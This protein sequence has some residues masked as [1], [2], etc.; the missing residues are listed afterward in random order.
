MA[1]LQAG[2]SGGVVEPRTRM[3]R[4]ASSSAVKPCTAWAP[5]ILKGKN[6]YECHVFWKTTRNVL[7]LY[8]VKGRDKKKRSFGLVKSVKSVNK[9][10]V[11]GELSDYF[12]VKNECGDEVFFKSVLFN[13]G[14]IGSN[15]FSKMMIGLKTS[16]SKL[17]KYISWLVRSKEFYQHD[18]NIN[19]DLGLDIKDKQ[20]DDERTEFENFIACG[21]ENAT[22][23]TTSLRDAVDMI[24]DQ[25][26]RK[27]KSEAKDQPYKRLK[28]NERIDKYFKVEIS[29]PDGVEYQVATAGKGRV[30]IPVEQLS[31]CEK[32]HIPIDEGK[33]RQLAL[34]MIERFEPTSIYL[35]VV[36]A[37]QEDFDPVNLER[38]R[39]EVVHGRHRFSALKLLHK[40][41]KM[42]SLPTMEGGTVTCYVLG[43]SDDIG[44]NYLTLRGNDLAAKHVNKPSLHD[45]FYTLQGLSLIYSDQE[46]V[47]KAITRFANLQ[48][49]SDAQK[50]ALRSF[51]KWTKDA[52]SKVKDVL[53]KYER[54]QVKDADDA[55]MKKHARDI[56]EGKK[57]ICSSELFTGLA[58]M[59]V[60][61]FEENAGDIMSG[62][63]SLK[64]VVKSNALSNNLKLVRKK[65][66]A[67]IVELAG[68]TS[69]ENVRNLY[70][71]K[72][73]EDVIDKLPVQPQP[74]SSASSL[75]KYTV[76][77]F[78]ND[79]D[80]QSTAKELQVIELEQD[81]EELR[82]LCVRAKRK[83]VKEMIK[84]NI[85]TVEAK[86]AKINPASEVSDPYEF[87]VDKSLDVSKSLKLDKEEGKSQEEQQKPQEEQQKSQEEQRKSQQEQ[88]KSQQEQQKSQQEQQK[89]EE[90]ATGERKQPVHHG[91]QVDT[92]KVDLER[93]KDFIRILHKGSHE[94]DRAHSMNI[95]LIKSF[96]AKQEEKNPFSNKEIDDFIDCMAK[97]KK[98]MRSSDIVFM[99]PL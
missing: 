69:I 19:T 97:E 62:K 38:N 53:V 24:A 48:K 64:E 36:P 84:Q 90:T 52:L 35:T 88:Q 99:I 32:V 56:Q 74:S 57:F 78:K 80:A 95:Q 21:K 25:T 54:F 58:R 79:S 81:L 93:Y 92:M 37:V 49:C 1:D 10:N 39:Y 83:N 3:Q 34:G 16:G 72:F 70:P 77:V 76:C 55:V 43:M 67:K 86:L 45:L 8:Q 30:D 68:F 94:N 28:K 4:S 46:V 12:A 60:N 23:V 2:P 73:T 42:T 26:K 5:V 71:D 41:E 14:L 22:I 98:V 31:L 17:A 47:M 63:L 40:E 44:L 27:R 13:P 65:K 15:S 18:P 96:C 50:A 9:K 11:K 29:D 7:E 6:G 20:T 85:G 89:M 82:T 91:V 75:E 61:S 51:S 59:P 87:K 33:V 66:E